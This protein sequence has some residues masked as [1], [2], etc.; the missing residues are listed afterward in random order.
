MK[1][2]AFS[3]L[4]RDV[5]AV[6]RIMAESQ[7]ADVIIGAGDFA[8]GGLGA[9]DTLSVLKASNVPVVIVSGNHDNTSVLLELCDDW[10]N[11]HLLHGNGITVGD[12]DFFGLGDEVPK[13]HN[14]DWNQSLTE[15]E[16][17]EI[18]QA[19]PVGAVLVTHNPPFGYCD[20][21]KNG[22]HEGSVAIFNAIKTKQPIL[23]LCGHIH[24]SWNT[25]AMVGNTQV[26]NLGPMAHW[27]EV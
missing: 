24:Q 10:E 15:D 3:D 19:C 27:L 5:D 20:L 2:L 12:V 1:V 22:T 9:E 7:Q 16:A 17:A 21:Q 18:L 14:E 8:T 4:H 11:G 6:Q 26:Y 23:N 25:T 13:R